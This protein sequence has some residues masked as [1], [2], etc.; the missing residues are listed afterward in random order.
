[1]VSAAFAAIG[2]FVGLTVGL[3]LPWAR[4]RKEKELEAL[5]PRVARYLFY[6][7][8]GALMLLS[9]CFSIPKVMHIAKAA[10][11]T[12]VI[13]GTQESKNSFDK[14]SFYVEYS[15][16]RGHYDRFAETWTP[17]R[18]R[19]GDKVRVLYSRFRS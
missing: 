3:V 6:G 2:T 4:S 17:F 7:F 19:I 16:P 9:V 13:T 5:R 1:L 18:K 11:T 15:T 12:G 10:S 14:Y 8:G